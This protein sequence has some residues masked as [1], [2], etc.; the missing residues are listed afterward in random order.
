MEKNCIKQTRIFIYVFM[1]SNGVKLICAVC[2]IY[3][4]H[5]II[6]FF[7]K[8]QCLKLEMRIML[9]EK[10]NNKKTLTFFMAKTAHRMYG[11][12]IEYQLVASWRFHNAFFFVYSMNAHSMVNTSEDTMCSTPTACTYWIIILMCT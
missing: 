4:V 12:W 5:R 3:N 9:K 10:S 11:S 8:C 6:F 2:R 7:H 1:V